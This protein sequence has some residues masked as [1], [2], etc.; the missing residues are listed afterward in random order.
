MNLLIQFFNH[1]ILKFI[2]NLILL[3]LAFVK[4]I[5]NLGFTNIY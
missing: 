1:D 5:Q 3:N 2:L 4:I